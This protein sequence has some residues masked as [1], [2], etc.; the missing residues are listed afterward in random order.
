MKFLKE[1]TRIGALIYVVVC[2]LQV[3]LFPPNFLSSL[4]NY[5]F[6]FALI[7][8]LIINLTSKGYRKISIAFLLFFSW[9]LISEYINHGLDGITNIP[10]LLYFLKWPAILVTLLNFQKNTIHSRKVKLFVDGLFFTI[11]SINLFL[12]INPFGYGEILQNIFSP[13]EYANFVYYNEFRN[14]RLVGT[15]MNPNDNAVILSLFYFYYLLMDSK[16]WYFSI[17]LG[18]LVLLT[19]SRTVFILLI[20]LTVVFLFVKLKK[21]MSKK[22]FFHVSLFIGIFL[23]SFIYSSNNLRSIFTGEAFRSHSVQVRLDNFTNAIDSNSNSLSLGNG[24][25]TNPVEQFGVH[26]DSEFIVIILQFGII[27]LVFWGLILLALATQFKQKTI[28][29]SYWIVLIILIVGV[30]LTNFTFTHSHIGVAITF[31]LGVIYYSSK[32]EI[33]PP[34]TGLK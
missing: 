13:K 14:F 5:F 19:Q 32:D 22:R 10:Y 17:I 1:I 12:L 3:L 29:F 2:I 24:V 23:I 6:I 20:L 31:F 21:V 27:G 25:I 15:Q 28:A 34:Q 33:S 7:H 4:D 9:S 8:I 16:K 18:G 11:V 30:S 26:I